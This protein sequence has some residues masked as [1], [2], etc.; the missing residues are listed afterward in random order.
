MKNLKSTEYQRLFKKHG[1][2]IFFGYE[3]EF[4]FFLHV[5]LLI[6][7]GLTFSI[8]LRTILDLL[9][10]ENSLVKDICHV[11]S[12]IFFLLLAYKQLSHWAIKIYIR[13]QTRIE[14]PKEVMQT[15]RLRL[16][17]YRNKYSKENENTHI[18]NFNQHYPFNLFTCSTINPLSPLRSVIFTLM[19]TSASGFNTKR[20]S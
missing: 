11:V 17:Y 1:Q 7:T 8:P 3:G 14:K 6:I 16:M 2:E 19:A 5:I 13:Y 18:E 12:E 9:W 4:P 10:Q 20:C 15:A